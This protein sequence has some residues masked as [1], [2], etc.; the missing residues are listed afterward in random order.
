MKTLHENII[1]LILSSFLFFLKKKEREKEVSLFKEE[2][3]WEEKKMNA[4]M[5]E[6]R[7]IMF[8]F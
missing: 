3:I 5:L 1:P 7:K 6:V 2:R 4:K 8:I